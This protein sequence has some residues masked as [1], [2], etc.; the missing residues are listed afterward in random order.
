MAGQPTFPQRTPPQEIAGLMIRVYDNHWV[1][2]IRP[3]IKSLFSLGGDTFGGDWLIS[4]NPWSRLAVFQ[5]QPQLFANF[6]VTKGLEKS[7]W[8][9]LSLCLWAD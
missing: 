2:L 1:P 8:P 7:M 4:H 5:S 6:L 3:T 9:I